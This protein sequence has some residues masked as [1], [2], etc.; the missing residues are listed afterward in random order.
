[1]S[2]DA[3]SA[4]CCCGG[5]E[6]G[7]IPCA[8]F[9]ACAPL[10]LSFA[11]DESSTTSRR[12]PSGGQYTDVVTKTAVATLNRQPDGVYRGVAIFGFFQRVESELATSAP[13]FLNFEEDGPC[14]G[15]PFGCPNLDCCKTL[16][17]SYSEVSADPILV[18]MSIS[19]FDGVLSIVFDDAGRVADETTSSWS[20]CGDPQTQSST[21]TEPCCVLLS[22]LFNLPCSPTV[23]LFFPASCNLTNALD[24]LNYDTTA[25]TTAPH[26]SS[27]TCAREIFVSPYFEIT[28]K[29]GTTNPDGGN[30]IPLNCGDVV[31]V[32]RQVRTVTLA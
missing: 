11:W 14:D 8:Q 29:C 27:L 12:W 23:P 25:T 18:D 32:T 17:D 3:A 7:G 22:A 31:T 20:R 4:G 5:G 19:C 9:I 10:T 13:E 26:L 15:N 24:Y 21:R 2:V 28:G 16:L 30:D 1:M 6:G